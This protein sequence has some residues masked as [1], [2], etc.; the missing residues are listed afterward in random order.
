[1]MN[2][3]LLVGCVCLAVVGSVLGQTRSSKPN[4][5]VFVTTT[6]KDAVLES[7]LAGSFQDA[8]QRSGRFELLARGTDL[9]AL[10][11]EDNLRL[12]G[13][14]IN[15][16][17]QSSLKKLGADQLLVI[18]AS[19]QGLMLNG[20]RT[21]NVSTKLISVASSK[22]DPNAGDFFSLDKSR[23]SEAGSK[24]LSTYLARAPLEGAI[25]MLTPQPRINLGS[26]QGLGRLFTQGKIIRRENAG[27]PSEFDFVIGEF[28]LDSDSL[29][30]ANCGI[31]F[32]SNLKLTPRVGDVV[33]LGPLERQSQ[34]A[35][36]LIAATSD[37]AASLT[38]RYAD[39]RAINDFKVR[40]GE[41]I[42]LE[43][44]VTKMAGFPYVLSF[45]PNEQE[46]YL[47]YPNQSASKKLVLGRSQIFPTQSDPLELVAQKPYGKTLVK[48]LVTRDPI[49]AFENKLENRM[50]A[51]Q[52]K[53][54]ND[55]LERNKGRWASAS[56]VFEIT[57]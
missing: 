48:L 37:Q 57:P 54:V 42:Q 26:D 29:G 50:G 34:E 49:P 39:G 41:K 12:S 53:S 8:I 32:S 18:D 9:A 31:T 51:I 13:V 19:S 5:V 45:F 30:K 7:T 24:W 52:A 55:F 2:R 36:D 16:N 15:A 10:L 22:S 3:L 1:M 27:T 14:T 47:L 4:V 46:F 17:Q 44:G 35:R 23:S 38:V 25:T 21:V 11:K 56:A 20:S 28:E 33:Q 40:E 43:F 6:P